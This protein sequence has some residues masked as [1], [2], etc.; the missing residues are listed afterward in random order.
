VERAAADRPAGDD[1]RKRWSI[2]T[3]PV[4]SSST[5]TQPAV[6]L[7]S[8]SEFWRSSQQGVDILF[9]VGSGGLDDGYPEWIDQGP[10]VAVGHVPAD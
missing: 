6:A 8:S 9:G 5:A 1:P 3:T 10:P 4:R 2:A 7:L